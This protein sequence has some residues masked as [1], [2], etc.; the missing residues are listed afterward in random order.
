MLIRRPCPNATVQSPCNAY[1]LPTCPQHPH[2]HAFLITILSLA[3][4]YIRKVHL[5]MLRLE[6]P[7]NLRL[8]LLITARLARLLLPLIIHHLL[9]HPAGLAVQ[10]AELAVLG[11]DFADI[12]A[13][14]G[15][16]DVLPPLHLVGLRELDAEFFGARGRAFERPGGVV[17]E[18][19]VGECALQSHCISTTLKKRFAANV[20]RC[21]SHLN[22]SILPLDPR[23][24]APLRNLHI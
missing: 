8:L 17:E 19:G 1:M 10:I 12:D 4:L 20:G 9:D 13:R 18:D 2:N 22:D 23:L 24:H 15:S 3:H 16:H 5:R 14:R 6:L 11:R 21:V 7:H